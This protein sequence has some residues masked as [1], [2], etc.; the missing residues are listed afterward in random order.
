MLANA[1]VKEDKMDPRTK[2]TRELLLQ[3]F[4]QL[5]M[6]KSFDSI[7][8]QEIAEQ[9]TVNRATFYAHFE[10]KYALLDY[11]FAESF[12]KALYSKLPP[13]SRLT[14][15]NLQLLIQMVCGYLDELHTH[16]T[17]SM[18]TQFD[19]LVE[20][21]AKL[22]LYQY[23]VGWLKQDA[24]ALSTGLNNVELRA[25]VTSWAIYGTA[26]QWSHSEKKESV[27]EFSRQALPLILGGLVA[28]GDAA[29]R[30]KVRT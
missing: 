14:P 13:D 23:L 5:L 27:E 8:I 19:S 18:G 26:V 17:S 6:T 22:Q 30:K 4:M 24:L 15:M 16:C 21:Q 2:R 3:A 1:S 11:V 28:P 25:T 10:D 9:A 7:T 20:Q 29:T 12:K